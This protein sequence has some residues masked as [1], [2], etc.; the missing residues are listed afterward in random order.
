MKRVPTTAV[1]AAKVSTGPDTVSNS[2]V[3]LFML[4]HMGENASVCRCVCVCVI[5]YEFGGK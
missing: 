1:S 5:P 2:K 3:S 4:S